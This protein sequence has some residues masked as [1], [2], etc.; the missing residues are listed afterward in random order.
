MAELTMLELS[1]ELQ[2]RTVL[3][4]VYQSDFYYLPEYHSI[5]EDQGE[6]H[7]RLFVYSDRKFI[8]AIP[9]LLRPLAETT[10]LAEI[11]GDWQDATS[12]YGY[13]GPLASHADMPATVVKG[14]KT[15]LS[16]ALQEQKVVTLF[17]RLH[18]LIPQADWIRGMGKRNVLGQTVSIDLALPLAQQRSKYRANH[19]QDVNR[20]RRLGIVSYPVHSEE[21]WGR[22]IDI[23]YQTMDRVHASRRYFFDRSDF[24]ALRT[25]LGTTLTLFVCQWHDE[26]I[27][28]GLFSLH[29]GIVQYYLGGTRNGYLKYAP[30]KLLFDSVRIWA[31]QRKARIFHLGGGIGS[32]EDSLF[33]FKAGFSDQR[34]VF[35]IWKWIL[36][37][38][39][40]G[41]LCVK[42]REINQRK[43]MKVMESGYFPEYRNPALEQGVE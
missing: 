34:H 6:G 39:V 10:E 5:A 17:T 24:D 23:Y 14:F 40:Y 36:Q 37:P 11:A 9:L 42:K 21:H 28:G 1:D 12:V 25:R 38:K 3:R 29:Q 41:Q 31:T 30:M 16:A 43:G 27:C 33:Q 32:N 35:S 4:H 2:W 7:A 15:A 19:R 22:F 18:P 26:I 8:M 20:L 13:A